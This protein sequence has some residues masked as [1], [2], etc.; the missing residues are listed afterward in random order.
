MFAKLTTEV[1]QMRTMIRNFVE[2]E[3]EPCAQQIE[4]ED[5]IPEHLVEKAKALGLFGMSIPE[6][7][8]GIGLNTVGKAVILQELGRT[9]NG[10]VSLISAHTGIGSTGLVKLASERLKEKYLPRMATGELIA[11]FALSEPSAGSDATNLKTRAEKRGDKWI[12]NGMKHFITNGPVADVI[13]VFAVTDKEKGAKGGIT[14]FL[15]EKNF[16]GF[17]VG[18]IDKKMGLRGSYTSQ[19]IFEDCE[20]PEENVIGEVGM[21]YVSALKIL[22]EGRVGLAARSVGSCDKLIEMS[23]RYAKERVQF[24]KPIAENQGIQWMLAEMATET[25]AARTLTLKA[26]QLIDEG[27]KAIKEASMAK[28]FATEVFNRVADKA[29]QIHGGMGYIAEYP[30]ERFY[31]DARI[32]KIYE[33]TN[34]IQKIIIARQVLNEV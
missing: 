2:N 16:P 24:G 17:S 21:G 28:L 10:F 30:A 25:E 5:A 3:V 11:A 23:A 22:G 32:T 8:G 27:K 18:K 29:V 20:V 1:E 13:T 19:I 34:E 12:L 9:H 33:G 26:A 31:R 15:V 4:E 7:Y 6:E 14:A